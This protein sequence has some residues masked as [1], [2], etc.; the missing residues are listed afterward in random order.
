M[1]HTGFLLNGIQYVT[2]YFPFIIFKE[3]EPGLRR[4]GD[5]CTQVP[6]ISCEKYHLQARSQNWIKRLLPSS[7]LSVRPPVCSQGTIWLPL[8]GFS[9]N[10]VLTDCLKICQQNSGLIKIWHEYRVL[11][12]KTCVHLW[13]FAA[14]KLE[15]E[16][17]RIN[18]EETIKIYILRSINL[19]R[20]S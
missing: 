12:T 20:K 16:I 10:L 3:T 6:R 2:L 11:Y 18:V 17:F 8:D 7:C 5:S 4:T 9:W 13:H 1:G 15:L 19:F 14:S